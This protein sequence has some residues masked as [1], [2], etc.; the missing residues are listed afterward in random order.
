MTVGPIGGSIIAF[1]ARAR[2]EPA[3]FA[4]F[5]QRRRRWHRH[6]C[7]ATRAEPADRRAGAEL[8]VSL[9]LRTFRGV[10]PTRAGEA[11]SREAA[12]ILRRIEQLP[13]VVRSSRGDPGRCCQP[14][15]GANKQGPLVPIH[16]GQPAG[17]VCQ[18]TVV[19]GSVFE[20]NTSISERHYRSRRQPVLAAHDYAQNAA[21]G[22]NPRRPPQ[23]HPAGKIDADSASE[24]QC[25]RP[26]FVRS[27]PRLTAP[28]GSPRLERTTLGSCSSRRKI[29]AASR[30]SASPARVGRTP[31]EVRSSRLTPSS[32]PARRSAGSARVAPHG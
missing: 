8:G 22:G 15:K 6:P 21:T 25:E 28:S 27:L 11:L 2:R 23:S 29:G 26:L 14:R 24:L 3:A 17:T 5:H 13:S 9:L 16:S 30:L 4:L 18:L 19:S 12:P 20:V 31:R 1:R 10:R 7:G 32:A